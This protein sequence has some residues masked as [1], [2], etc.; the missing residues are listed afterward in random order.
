MELTPLPVD[1]GAGT[2]LKEYYVQ[3]V[4]DKQFAYS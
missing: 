1:V 3:L 4:S 2:L